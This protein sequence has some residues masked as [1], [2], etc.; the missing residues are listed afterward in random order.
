MQSPL[1]TT[2]QAA[3]YLAVS[4]A[5]LERD[6]W[7]GA[8]INF[9]R[10]G[11]RLV[12]YHLD[13]LNLYLDA[14]IK[15]STSQAQDLPMRNYWVILITAYMSFALGAT[16]WHIGSTNPAKAWNTVH[17]LPSLSITRPK[18]QLLP[19]GLAA[20]IERRRLC[21]SSPCCY[22]IIGEHASMTEPIIAPIAMD[23]AIV[24]IIDFSPI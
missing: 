22:S 8:K 15:R 10:I 5:F 20:Q 1:L 14:Q 12:R 16:V 23:I 3:Q 21:Y 2:K 17:A 18:G 11:T 6:R 24:Q 9:R 4:S 13:D 7:A 19:L